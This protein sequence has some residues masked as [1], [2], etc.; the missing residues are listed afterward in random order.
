MVPTIAALHERG[1]AIARQ[2][3]AENSGRWESLERRR[4]RAARAGRGDDREAAAAPA[5]AAAQ[6]ARRRPAHLR[7]RAGAARAVRPRA[8]S[9]ARRSTSRRRAERRS[10]RSRRRRR[11]DA[12]PSQA[13]AASGAERTARAI[14]TRGSALALAQA[15]ARRR[16]AARRSR[17]GEA[18]LVPITTSGDRGARAGDKSRFVKEIEEALLAGEVDLAV[19]S[20]KD[21]PGRAARRASRSPR[22]PPA[23]DPRDA[24][25]GARVARRAAAGRAR[26]H[27]EP[28]AALAAAR[29]PPRPRGRAA[30]RQRRHAAA[31]AR[32]GRAT[33]RSCSRSPACAG[34]AATAEAGAALDTDALRAGARP[35]HCWRSR[36]ART[37]TRDR[38]A[39]RALEDAAARAR[40]CEAERAVV[41]EL[42][43]SCHTPV[44]AHARVDGETASACTPTSACPTAASGSPTGC[45]ADAPADPARARGP[46]AGAAGCWPPAPGRAA[47]PGWTDVRS[48]HEPSRPGH[49]VP[50][51]R[52]PGRSGPRDGA[53]AS[54]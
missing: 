27:L 34:W 37:T 39:R 45:R 18:E 25:V 43:A 15:R 9:S 11:R 22:C 53:R 28:A 23:E 44:G 41:D 1:E 29:D 30:A 4:P 26:R 35:G 33:T 24:L 48:A 3:L 46:R 38:G 5:D 31:Q 6:G 40:G 21:V 47:A 19:H 10:R 54:S 8:R 52:G 42:D 14:G 16:R 7:V 20:A 32:R 36:R 51:R 17:R 50:G 12:D 49:R 2:V 13:T